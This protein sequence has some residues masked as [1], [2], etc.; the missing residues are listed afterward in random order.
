MTTF[1]LT[2]TGDTPSVTVND[3]EYVPALKADGK[4]T[5]TVPALTP[6]VGE[7]L[8]QEAA[9]GAIDHFSAPFP[10]FRMLTVCEGTVVPGLAWR[11]IEVGETESVVA[12]ETD[13]PRISAVATTVNNRTAKGR[14]PIGTPAQAP[15]NYS[16]TGAAVNR[17]TVWV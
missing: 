16:R 8:I 11:L 4:L 12:A 3:V 7:T 13:H 2:V 1:T 6:L 15:V 9:G 17:S 5:V 10:S 14:I